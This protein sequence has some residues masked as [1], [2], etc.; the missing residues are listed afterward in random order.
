MDQW[1][2]DPQSWNLYSYVRN[3]PLALIDPTGNAAQQIPCD[4]IWQDSKRKAEEAP[5]QAEAEGIEIEVTDTDELA[6]IQRS[7]LGTDLDTVLERRFLGTLKDAN[8][9]YAYGC[10]R[11]NGGVC[12]TMYGDLMVFGSITK[13][14]GHVGF[15]E[16][17]AEIA[18]ST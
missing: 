10:A 15:S 13:L 14:G 5:K 7:Q 1:P 6:G 12:G 11:Q 18:N 9:Y 2:G 3:N 8:E 4:E 16:V 17:V